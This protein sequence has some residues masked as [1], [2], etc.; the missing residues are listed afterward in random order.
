[1]RRKDR[2]CSLPEFFDEV[3]AA[4]N[5]IFIA[6]HDDKYPYCLPFNFARIENKI[7]IHCAKEGKKL[8]LIRKNPHI[9]FCIVCDVKIDTKKATTYYK[10]V[11]GLGIAAIVEDENEK[12]IALDAIA[13]HYNAEK[14]NRPAKDAD[15]NRTGI[16]CIEIKQLTGKR[17]LQQ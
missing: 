5:E 1:M 6:F 10:S 14:C 9:S 3:F 12:R 8:D 11:C 17:R 4:A 7:Y 16:F 13:L 2:A 15:V